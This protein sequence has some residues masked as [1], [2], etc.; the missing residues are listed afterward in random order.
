MAFNS[1][2][3]QTRTG[4]SL[5]GSQPYVWLGLMGAPPV[6]FDWDRTFI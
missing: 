3:L 6:A 1:L 4:P 5:V 2:R